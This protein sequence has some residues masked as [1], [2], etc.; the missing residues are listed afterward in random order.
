MFLPLCT[1]PVWM[2]YLQL[3][4]VAGLLLPVLGVDTALPQVVFQV[5]ALLLPSAPPPGS[6]PVG[7]FTVQD[8]LGKPGPA[9]ASNVTSPE[10]LVLDDDRLNTCDISLFQI[11]AVGSSVSPLD[12]EYMAE[13]SLMILLKG[14]EVATISSPSF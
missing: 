2:G 11:T 6:L 8:L 14:F 9:P 13:T 3:G 12:V 1:A 5:E 4:L 10:M 7:Q